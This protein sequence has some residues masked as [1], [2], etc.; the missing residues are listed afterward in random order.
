VAG[1]QGLA[2][3]V[4]R[5]G[6][7]G[8]IVMTGWISAHA[9]R[10]DPVTYEPDVKDAAR[11]AQFD[12]A[13][14]EAKVVFLAVLIIRTG[15]VPLLQ[16]RPAAAVGLACLAGCALAIALPYTPAGTW[17]GLAPLPPATLTLLL[18]TVATYLTAL[19]AAKITYHR[20]IGR[21]L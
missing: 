16:S 3:L 15:R 5:A 21:W 17:L 9:V 18:L 10:L 19:Q 13:L 7:L 12:A 20:T 1:G 11:L 6:R 14:G 2:W 8:G 4:L